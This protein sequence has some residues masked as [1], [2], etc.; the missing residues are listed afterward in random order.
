MEETL[1]A[2]GDLLI[3]A[4]PTVLFFIFLTLYLKSVLFKPLAK[5]FEERRKA[6][7]G[8]RELAQRAFEAA[9]KKTSEFEHALQMARAELH[10]ER[11]ALRRRWT[12]EQEQEIEKARAEAE[13]QIEDAKRQIG[14]E[15]EKAQAELDARMET[16]SNEI[17]KSLLQR[18][19]A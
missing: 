7:E 13:R 1:H 8:V 17:V 2:L 19:A 12:E 5:I 14:Q 11:E 6:T 15:V 9:E 10:Q 18:R 4:I 3:K 16:L